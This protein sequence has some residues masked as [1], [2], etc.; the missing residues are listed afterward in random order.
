MKNSVPSLSGTCVLCVPR[1][2]KWNGEWQISKNFGTCGASGKFFSK[3]RETLANPNTGGSRDTHGTHGTHGRTRA[4]GSQDHTWP[5][6][7]T[8]L[9]TQR[10]IGIPTRTTARDGRNRD[11][12]NSRKNSRRPRVDPT[13]TGTENVFGF[14]ISCP[15][16]VLYGMIVIGK[17]G[18]YSIR[19]HYR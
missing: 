9:Q 18:K 10:H 17:A 1:G 5:N 19:I 14:V 3:F 6:L 15:F 16:P 11:Q 7:T 8:I 13:C 4:H 2:G 12:L